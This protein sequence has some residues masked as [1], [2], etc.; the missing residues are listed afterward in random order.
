MHAHALLICMYI[1]HFQ[2]EMNCQRQQREEKQW[3]ENGLLGIRLNLNIL[4]EPNLAP[5]A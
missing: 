1:N 4:P 3:R 2:G 5:A